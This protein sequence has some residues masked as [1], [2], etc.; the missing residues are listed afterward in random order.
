MK[1]L[2]YKVERCF[3]TSV[4]CSLIKKGVDPTQINFAPSTPRFA[5][6]ARKLMVRRW[7][8]ANT[9]LRKTLASGGRPG[10][11]IMMALLGIVREPSRIFR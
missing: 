7:L 6:Y 5:A 2:V 10:K 3:Y 9:N 4:W 11:Q 1:L 8:C